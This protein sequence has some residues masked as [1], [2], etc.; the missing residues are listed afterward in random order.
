MLVTLDSAT[1]CDLAF[2]VAGNPKGRVHTRAAMNRRSGRVFT[3][4]DASPEQMSWTGA[5]RDAAIQTMR[6]AD[7]AKIEVGAVALS[8]EF[9]MPRPQA[10]H[11]KGA[12]SEPRCCRGLDLGNLTKAL[13]DSLNGVVWRDDSMISEYRPPYLRRYAKP[14]EACGAWVRV[15]RLGEWIDP[16]IALYARAEHRGGQADDSGAARMDAH[17]GHPG[18]VGVGGGGDKAGVRLGECAQ[19]SAE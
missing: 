18:G 6:E 10:Y 15:W 19:G 11:W 4:A 3:R 9:V 17:T 1:D 12:H 7:F 16:A 2:F 8:V 13:E 14:G 5:V